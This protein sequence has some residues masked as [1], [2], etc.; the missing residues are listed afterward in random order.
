MREGN[1]DSR[2]L[3]FNHD[4]SRLQ[5]QKRRIIICFFKIIAG[6]RDALSIDQ[7]N[8]NLLDLELNWFQIDLSPVYFGT[9]F[10]S[11]QLKIT[12]LFSP[13]AFVRDCACVVSKTFH[14]VIFREKKLYHS[15]SH[16]KFVETMLLVCLYIE[17]QWH[18]MCS[19]EY[20]M[21]STC[22]VDIRDP[23]ISSYHFK[24]AFKRY[25]FGCIV[26]RSYLRTQ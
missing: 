20:M 13:A 12:S 9:Y 18:N 21:P 6:I 25:N 3:T 7:T 22:D 23:L 26:T 2:P 11:P 15:R 19:K 5:K 14:F 16:L 1:H 10:T 24:G 4:N 17:G 8:G